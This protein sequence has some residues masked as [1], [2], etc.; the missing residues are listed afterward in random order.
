MRGA[1]LYGRTCPGVMVKIE[2]Q[3]MKQEERQRG[4][5]ALMNIELSGTLQVCLGQTFGRAGL[6]I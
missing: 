5:G 3:E 2:L 1:E 4:P 6:R